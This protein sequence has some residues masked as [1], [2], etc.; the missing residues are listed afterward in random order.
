[1]TFLFK[2]T[3]VIFYTGRLIS[4]CIE[5]YIVRNPGHSSLAAVVENLP[6]RPGH[7]RFANRFH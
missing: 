1:M 5:A 7:I 3:V 6:H 4:N 2:L